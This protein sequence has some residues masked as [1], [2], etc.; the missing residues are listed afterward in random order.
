MSSNLPQLLRNLEYQRTDIVSG[1]ESQIRLSRKLISH[2][3]PG[4]ELSEAHRLLDPGDEKS[5]MKLV[6]FLHEM[7]AVADE[8]ITDSGP[9]A[10]KMEE[11]YAEIS[12]E[13]PPLPEPI[14][15]TQSGE[16]GSG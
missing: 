8:L 10:D 6:T 3:S 15:D 7:L 2:I 11:Y 12:Q 4:S 5:V 1:L 16:S 13:I 14:P 9:L